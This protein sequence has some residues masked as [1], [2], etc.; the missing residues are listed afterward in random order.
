MHFKRLELLERFDGL[1]SLHDALSP[2][3]KDGGTTSFFATNLS[4]ANKKPKYPIPKSVF[5]YV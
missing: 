1:N 3:K 4:F 5:G 2:Q